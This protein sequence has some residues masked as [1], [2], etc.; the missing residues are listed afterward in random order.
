MQKSRKS[1]KISSIAILI[2]AA[3]DLLEIFANIIYGFD[4]VAIPEGAPENIILITQI[5]LAVMSFL[6]LLPWVY[7]GVKGLKEAK[8]P[9]S[10]RAHIVWGIILTVIEIIGVISAVMALISAGEF[11]FANDFGLFYGIVKV[12][13]FFDYVNHARAVA[14]ES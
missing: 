11:S 6:L 2:L 14:K 9:T 7:V 5:T 1:L 8:N 12:T 3:S 10:A 13:V 4:N